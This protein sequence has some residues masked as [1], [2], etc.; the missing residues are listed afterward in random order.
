MVDLVYGE[1]LLLPSKMG[2]QIPGICSP[3]V[4]NSSEYLQEKY[5]QPKYGRNSSIKSLNYDDG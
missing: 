4:L 3:A 2:A 1:E 5:S